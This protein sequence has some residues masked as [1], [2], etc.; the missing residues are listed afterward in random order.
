M[1]RADRL[2]ARS[3][4][5]VAWAMS[6][7]AP[8]LG[9]AQRAQKPLSRQEEQRRK[10]LEEMGLQKND[11]PPPA[12]AP[13][14]PT[15]DPE[16]ER[17][18]ERA[19]DGEEPRAERKTGAASPGA[20]PS[21]APP[22]FRRAIHP[23]LLQGCKGCH[24]SGAAAQA[25]AL[26]LSGD[27]AA[28]HAVVRRALDLHAPAASALLAKASGQKLHGG[29]APWP[30]GGGPYGRVLAWIQ[31]GARLDGGRPAAP[32]APPEPA[33][34]AAP[35]KPAHRPSVKP[36]AAAPPASATLAAPVAVAAEEPVPE[37]PAQE[38]GAP[39]APP[40]PD[41]FAAVAHPLL[42]RACAACHGPTGPAATTRLVLTG[43]VAA[44]YTKVRALVDPAAPAASPLLTKAAGETHAGGPILKAGSPELATLSSWVSAGALERPVSAPARAPKAD[45]IG[46]APRPASLAPVAGTPAAS[47]PTAHHGAGGVELPFGLLLNGRFD[48]AYER[49]DFTGNPLAGKATNVLTSYHH[50][51]FLS[52]QSADDPF[53]LSLEA[54]SLQFWEAHYRWR[55][56][57]LPIQVLVS[58][59]KIFVPFGADPLM[60]Q[61]YGGLAGFDQKILP[62]IWAQE[63]AAVHVTWQ[64]RLFAVTD[65]LY[66]VRG[67][68]LRAA[69]GVLNLQN[70]I[71]PADDVKVGWGNRL[72][73][74][75]GPLSAWY[76]AYYNPLGFG[77]R[78][79]MQAADVTLS[80]IRSVP[81]LGHF[82]LAAGL[83]R[84]DVSGGGDAGVGGP[85]KDYYHFGSY[86]Q[87]RYHP[88]DWLTLQYRQGVRTFNN[89]RG[90]IVDDTRLT[91]DDASTHNFGVWA[92][93]QGLTAGLFYFL[94]L[95]KGPEI[96]ND[97][98]R[99]SVTY[100]F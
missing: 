91:S 90:A 81:V 74:A 43:E 67:Y 61:S 56:G 89:R 22:S 93:Y 21:P 92:R 42:M 69:D 72:G 76:S 50:F 77:R 71:S 34:P 64:R 41:D 52:R 95:E 82:S 32:P 59:G 1:S 94:N 33:G 75:L 49:R 19:T 97:L 53:G 85:G 7:A 8:S 58:G 39:A 29:G 73:A 37:E 78:L 5:F 18:T 25:T 38:A 86:F 63:G 51:L 65:D 68:A 40:A 66:V 14:V 2:A 17:Q 28:D 44:D 83:L 100:E 84:A 47:P 13:A 99:A 9:H 27:A 98:F 45:A 87:L 6:V 10:L 46:A 96:P 36:T 57:R 12:A 31:A 35:A 3:F 60:H 54:L 26:V 55:P 88:T 15:S 48:L 11:A 80:R 62:V 16:A 79:F 4:A 23:L 30:A 20:A 24:A 70:D